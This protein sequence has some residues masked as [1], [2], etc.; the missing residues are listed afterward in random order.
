MTTERPY[1][2][3]ARVNELVRE[4]LADEL[5][6]LSDPR[7]GFVTVTGV[8]VSGDLRLAT[9]YYSVLG[10]DEAHQQSAEALRSATPHLRKTIGRQVRLKYLPNLVFT[11]DPAMA[12]GERVEQIIR[13]LHAQEKNER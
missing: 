9:V 7:L 3:M 2:R 11:E 4:V 1:P 10:P 13:Q 5:E 6:R 12:Q 8:E